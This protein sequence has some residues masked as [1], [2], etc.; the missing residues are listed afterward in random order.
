PWPREQEAAR[1]RRS[2]SLEVGPDQPPTLAVDQL[3]FPPSDIRS[4]SSGLQRSR[5]GSNPAGGRSA[6]GRRTPV[7]RS[8]SIRSPASSAAARA[9]RAAMLPRRRAA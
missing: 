6:G 5:F 7:S 9:P 2:Q 1:L 3:G 8:L 4:Q